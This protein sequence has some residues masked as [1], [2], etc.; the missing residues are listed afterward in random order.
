MSAH[1]FQT[2]VVWILNNTESILLTTFLQKDETEKHPFFLN[3]KKV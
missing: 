3:E 2:K 1:F